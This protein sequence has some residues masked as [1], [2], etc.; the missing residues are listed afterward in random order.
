MTRSHPEANFPCDCVVLDMAADEP[1]TPIV[2]DDRTNEYQLVHG[3]DNGGHMVFY[4]CPFCGGRTPDTRRGR[5]FARITLAEMQRLK[6]LTRDIRTIDDAIR[7]LGEPDADIPDGETSWTDDSETEPTQIKSYRMITYSG[8]SETAVV[9]IT[10]H[11]KE[12]VE[13]QFTGK[14]LNGNQ[15]AQSADKPV[16]ARDTRAPENREAA[17]KTVYCS[18]CEQSEHGVERMLRSRSAAIC[19]DCAELFLQSSGT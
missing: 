5:L 8:L 4:Y 14:F 7:I 6:E 15:S 9:E 10:D 17:R 16:R 11:R 19:N 13:I 3:K 18:F 1:D 12:R 2:F